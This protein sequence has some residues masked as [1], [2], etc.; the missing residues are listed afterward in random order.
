MTIEDR[1]ER[2]KR[3]ARVRGP[4]AICEIGVGA[5]RRLTTVTLAH[6]QS[7]AMREANG[8]ILATDYPRGAVWR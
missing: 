7:L 8:R 5:D 6:A 4:L 2:A 3:M 1:I